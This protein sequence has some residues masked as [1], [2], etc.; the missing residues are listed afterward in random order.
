M[1][2]VSLTSC[3]FSKKWTRKHEMFEILQEGYK[4]QHENHFSGIPFLSWLKF[5]KNHGQKLVSDELDSKL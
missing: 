4:K 3:E 5:I 2:V 1:P